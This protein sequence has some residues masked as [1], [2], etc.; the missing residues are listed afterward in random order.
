MISIRLRLPEDLGQKH[1][2]DVEPLRR[3]GHQLRLLLLRQLG[4]AT[5][6]LADQARRHMK[7][8]NDRNGHQG[9]SWTHC[10]NHDECRH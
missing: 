6:N 9:Q 5:T 4:E 1:P 7:R 8:W 3:E 10:E 2:P